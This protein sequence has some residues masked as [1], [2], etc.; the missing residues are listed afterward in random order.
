MTT[1]TTSSTSSA[2]GATSSRLNPG[3]RCHMV[4]G[5]NGE[6]F[7]RGTNGEVSKA[8]ALAKLG[9]GVS[10]RDYSKTEGECLYE[11]TSVAIHQGTSAGGALRELVASHLAATDNSALLYAPERYGE[12]VQAVRDG[13]ILQLLAVSQVC[14]RHLACYQVKDGELL[15]TSFPSRNAVESTIYL[16][17]AAAHY[18]ALSVREGTTLPAAG[19]YNNPKVPMPFL[20]ESAKRRAAAARKA[21]ETKDAEDGDNEA[22]T[23]DDAVLVSDG[24]E[25]FSGD[26]TPQVGRN[27]SVLLVPAGMEKVASLW[28]MDAD[29]KEGPTLVSRA[30]LP[31]MPGV[32]EQV[33]LATDGGKGRC[34]RRLWVTAKGGAPLKQV[35][36]T[37]VVPAVES[38]AAEVYLV[39][40]TKKDYHDARR[41]L[42]RWA[43][44]KCTAR[45]EPRTG[46]KRD[47]CA[48]LCM[49]VARADLETLYRHSG[50]GGV[51]VRPPHQ[52][53][54]KFPVLWIEGASATDAALLAKQADG[55]GVAWSKGTGEYGIR[56]KAERLEEMV[57]FLH[58]RTAKKV[59]DR[60]PVPI[61]GAPFT[62]KGM[63]TQVPGLVVEQRLRAIGWAAQAVRVLASGRKTCTWLVAS[64]AD[65]PGL[66]FES[67]DEQWLIR[68]HGAEGDLLKHSTW[69]SKGGAKKPAHKPPP[70]PATKNKTS[71]FPPLRP[72]AQPRPAKRPTRSEGAEQSF[73]SWW[74]SKEAEYA[75]KDRRHEETMAKLRLEQERR[76]AD[77]QAMA[78]ALREALAKITRMQKAQESTQMRLMDVEQQL[79]ELAAV[80]LTSSASRKR[81]AGGE[82]KGGKVSKSGTRSTASTPTGQMQVDPQHPATP[83]LLPQGPVQQQQQ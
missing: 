56:V 7:G 67:G 68:P 46:S 51:Y 66:M 12:Y 36:K 52:S 5:G 16:G 78:Q 57:A 72:A 71:D 33:V 3:Q 53:T 4:G 26:W 31:T 20:S 77:Q 81:T 14:R 49:V 29:D 41:D 54:S 82:E 70:P 75:E 38:C 32:L 34:V 48:E 73:H 63:G 43:A 23:K 74:Q 9:G 2:V 19:T 60:R 79:A 80:A 40:R 37:V 17:F 50:T 62:V 30:K 1:S 58:N 65:P 10:I 59:K 44:S 28:L 27:R 47:G 35:K 15:C 69:G 24:W 39:E 76:Q 18:V 8:K 42:V 45:V 64:E 13:D 21:K 22:T 61:K 6:G 83:L 25:A 11:A 55:L